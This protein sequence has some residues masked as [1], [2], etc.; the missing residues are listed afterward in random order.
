MATKRAGRLAPVTY[1]KTAEGLAPGPARIRATWAPSAK[2]AVGTALGNSRVW[3]SL[4]QGIVTEVYYPRPDIPQLKD[5]GFIVG[6]GKEFWVEL[7][8][9]GKYSVEWRDDVIP[10]ITVTHRHTR[11]TLTLRICA[12]VERDVL[13]VKFALAGDAGLQLYVLA[14]PRIG[15]DALNNQAWTDE[16][17]GHALIWAQ[18]GPFGLAIAAGG[19]DGRSAMLQRSVGFVGES[20]GWQD[21]TRNGRMSWHYAEAGP[22]TV[23]LT[24]Q[25]ARAGTLAVGFASS[26]EAAATLA[27]Q[28]LAGGFDA[29][30]RAYAQGWKQWLATVREPPKLESRLTPES[31]GLLR[32]SVTTIKVHEDRTYPGAFVASLSVPWGESSVSRGGYHLVWA[33]DLVETAG[34]LLALGCDVDARRIV[35]YLMATQQSDGHWLQNQW[36][37]GK[38]FWQ[39][40]QLDETAFPVLLA[41]ALAERG[42]LG[43]LKVADMV[44][45]ALQF[46]ATQGPSTDQGRWEEDAG[47][48][49]FTVAVAIAALVDGSRFLAAREAEC[50][51]MIADAWNARL[52]DWTWSKSTA[53]A[54]SLGVPGYYMRCAPRN[55]MTDK[56]AKQDALTIKNRADTPALPAD[57]QIAIDCLQ[58]VR[59]GLRSAGDAK[60]AAS[61]RAIDAQLKTETPQGP[62]WHR[63]NG[64]GYGEHADG[65]PFDGTGVGRGWPLLTG[66]RGH[67]ALLAGEDARP[68]LKSMTQ[69]TGW[70]GMLPEQ[71]WDAAAI[72]ERELY[73]GKPSG[74]AMPLVWAHAEFIKLALSVAQ[75]TPVDRPARTWSR[76]GG[77]RPK[78][79]YV[80]WQHQKRPCQVPAGFGL[81]L[82]L[83]E[84]ARVHWG[85]N[86]W[87]EPTDIE[88]EDWGLGHLVRLPTDGLGVGETV[89]FTFFWLARGAWQGEDYSVTIVDKVT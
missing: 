68:Y 5:L 60:M 89:Q 2:D 13:L 84:A 85:R 53:L 51:L 3:F 48:N 41:S 23:A 87:H 6:D 75:G 1:S 12:D 71:V 69:M 76:Y 54:R 66:E 70:G 15:E 34:A 7:R 83:R 45:R 78:I 8:R 64:D 25:L 26:R 32:R 73:P 67:V 11:F 61:I 52:D 72:P 20:D 39:G 74:S 19:R 82:L 63:Y 16:W 14:A 50:A 24:A 36:L 29:N 47:I 38:P 77:K 44:R 17:E 79:D 10:A 46:I 31:L 30:W 9:L 40:I 42:A 43:D 88:S 21:F 33:R 58:L 81:R 49:A 22:G 4:A 86:D 35:T 28:S 37:G 55:V 56:G 65:A 57:E 59:F 62:V 18:Q 80:L 27:L